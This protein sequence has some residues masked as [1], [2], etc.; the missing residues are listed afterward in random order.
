MI[1]LIAEETAILI[2]DNTVETTPEILDN[3]PDITIP[4]LV[5]C[6]LIA[7]PIAGSIVPKLSFLKAIPI[8]PIALAKPVNATIALS[9]ESIPPLSITLVID[10]TAV[11]PSPIASPAGPHIAYNTPVPRADVNNPFRYSLKPSPSMKL[12]K[13]LLTRVYWSTIVIAL[14]ASL[15]IVF[16]V[17]RNLSP[18]PSALP[19][20]VRSFAML[21]AAREAPIMA[22]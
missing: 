15:L 7:V 14:A 8:A 13:N 5:I 20:P 2:P 12:S 18:S 16:I 3:A 19:S 11:T 4:I 22:I 1:K 10:A 9:V 17:A 6:V 21:R